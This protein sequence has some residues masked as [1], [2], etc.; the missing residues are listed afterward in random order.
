MFNAFLIT[1]KCI[2]IGG[3]REVATPLSPENFTKKGHFRSLTGLQ[4]NFK[5]LVVKI[6]L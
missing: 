2:S 3:F 6:S 5:I 4:P 1:E